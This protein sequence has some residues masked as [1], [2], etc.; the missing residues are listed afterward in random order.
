M[1]IGGVEWW[2][3]I[4]FVSTRFFEAVHFHKD[5]LYRPRYNSPPV[6]IARKVVSAEEEGPLPECR[7]P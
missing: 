5:I 4:P 1:I 3:L 6:L 7:F 2:K